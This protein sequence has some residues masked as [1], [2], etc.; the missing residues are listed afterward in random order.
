MNIR[1][2]KG[3]LLLAA[4]L[5][6]LSLVGIAADEISDKAK[7]FQ[8][9]LE[10]MKGRAPGEVLDKLTGWKFEPM[11]AWMTEDPASKEFKKNN[12]GKTKFSKK[13]IAAIFQPAGKYKIAVYGLLV[14]KSSA[15]TGVVDEL[16]RGVGKDASY[17]VQIFTAIRIVFRDEKLI[18][19][20]TWPK[21]DRSA[22]SGGTWRD[23]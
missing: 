8:A 2:L 13:E 11:S 10:A 7:A 18:D 6:I 21:L 12:T 9:E 20:R 22:V 3:M 5:S 1:F 17:T 14:G 23:R 19:V 15:T 4:A 16:G